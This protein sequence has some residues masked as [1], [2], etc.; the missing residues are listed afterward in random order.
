MCHQ[1]TS[2]TRAGIARFKRYLAD[3]GTEFQSAF[4]TALD[5]V[6]AAAFS[7]TYMGALA[8]LLRHVVEGLMR[9]KD[10]PSDVLDLVE[11]FVR[12]L[13]GDG[14]RNPY[15]AV[16]QLEDAEKEAQM[17]YLAKAMVKG[18]IWSKEPQLERPVRLKVLMVGR[19]PLLIATT[20]DDKTES[21]RSEK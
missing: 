6:Q 20:D 11:T 4:R 1:G 18:L 19:T 2:W 15:P 16:K 7:C 14:S 8:E 9:H 3:P 12:G 5:F 10:C 13:L 17:R 21:S